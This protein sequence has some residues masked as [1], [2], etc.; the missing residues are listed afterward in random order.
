MR[1][2]SFEMTTG[3]PVTKWTD[4]D[5]VA[6]RVDPKTSQAVVV[7]LF[8]DQAQAHVVCMYIRANGFLPRHPTTLAQLFAV[9]EGEGW[10]SGADG[11]KVP[12]KT[13]Q[14][15]FWEAGEEHGSGTERG[16]KAIV[17][18]SPTFDPSRHMREV[19]G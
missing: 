16:L 9:V 4:K 17:I 10:V 15:A 18:E 2:F 7:P 1:L 3:S 6:H 19:R 13:G 5:G 14:A 8:A 12:I 11:E